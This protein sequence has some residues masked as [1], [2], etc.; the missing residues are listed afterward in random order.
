MIVIIAGLD[1]LTQP[2]VQ[3][4]FSLGDWMAD[5]IGIIGFSIIIFKAN[6]SYKKK[7]E[8]EM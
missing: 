1:E 5:I 4:T 7:Q 2:L 8:T 3:R 6:S